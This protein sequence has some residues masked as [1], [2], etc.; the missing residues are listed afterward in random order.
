[1]HNLNNLYGLI[2]PA[3]RRRLFSVGRD[4]GRRV[5]RTLCVNWFHTPNFSDPFSA[6][7]LVRA[8]WKWPKLGTNIF[9]FIFAQNWDPIYS[10]CDY[11]FEYIGL[12]VCD[13]FGVADSFTKLGP[14]F[15]IL[16]ELVHKLGGGLARRAVTCMHVYLNTPFTE[17]SL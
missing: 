9:I 17:T 8:T 4:P 10:F 13:D 11:F 3:G 2:P 1:M 6:Q 7:T 5:S 12:G 15:E 16:S 14:W